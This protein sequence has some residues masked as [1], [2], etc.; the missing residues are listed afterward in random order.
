M[1]K[2][3][4]TILTLLFI[5]TACREPVHIENEPE[6]NIITG[7]L[8]IVVAEDTT[9]P[10][11]AFVA[12]LEGLHS[13]NDT[14]SVRIVAYGGA[15]PAGY[16]NGGLY[17]EGQLS[18]VP[19][20][21][22]HQMGIKSF[23]SPLF[24]REKG[25]GSGYLIYDKAAD[26]P[27][28]KQVVNNSGIISKT[29]Y[30]LS[31]YLDTKVDNITWPEGPGSASEETNFVYPYPKR[32]NYLTYLHRFFNYR[33]N[34]H[35]PFNH[36]VDS[37]PQKTHLVLQ[38]EDLDFWIGSASY[39][40]NLINKLS[41]SLNEGYFY[42]KRNFILENVSN[43]RKM[44]LFNHPDIIDF[45]FF[46]LYDV[47]I[48]IAKG[49]TTGIA[50]DDSTLLVPTN[51]VK[52]AFASSDKKLITLKDE[53]VLSKDEIKSLR[54]SLALI[55][56]NLT[57]R[58]A[59]LYGLPLV[60]MADLYKKI[61]AREYYTEDGLFIDPSFPNGNFFSDDGLYPSIVGNGVIANETIKEINRVYKTKVPLIKV[62][63]LITLKK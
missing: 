54:I 24:E 46:H 20:M 11:T 35:R 39:P 45:P 19:H 9:L 13:T 57:K 48:L 28:W 56:E 33:N 8:N 3:V 7:S 30:V 52:K 27:S 50:L 4:L 43:D 44:V 34:W 38:F 25:N 2:L 47:K 12:N 58:Y 1:I 18:S 62:R 42:A 60:Q 10:P 36:F 61:F 6:A 31:P 22:A 59:N 40:E 41:S 15:L 51:N 14:S 29:P 32:K 17:R 26:L 23:I 5:S 16:R 37:I 63:E 49:N 53:D 21:I 55:N